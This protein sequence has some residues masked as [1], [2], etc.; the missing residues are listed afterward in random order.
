MESSVNISIV[1]KSK[2]L[3]N[4]LTIVSLDSVVFDL[5]NS[6]HIVVVVGI[7]SNKYIQKINARSNKMQN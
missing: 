5:P 3:A 1:I 7:V 4:V 2:P 6:V